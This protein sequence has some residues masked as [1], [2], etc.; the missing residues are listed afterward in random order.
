MQK[1]KLLTKLVVFITVLVIVLALALL[2]VQ[3][4]KALRW[5]TALLFFPIVLFAANLLSKRVEKPCLT[6]KS[7][8]GVR[9]GLVGGGVLIATSLITVLLEYYGLIADRGGGDSGGITLILPAIIAIF[10]DMLSDRLAKRAAEE[11][12]DEL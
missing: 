11:K 3:P 1:P 6:S 10:I 12:G 4:E 9:A 2:L 5:L 7:I 8:A